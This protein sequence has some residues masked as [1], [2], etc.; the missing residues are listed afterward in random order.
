MAANPI[1]YGKIS[2][3]SSAEALSATLYIANYI[4]ESRRLMSIFKWGPNFLELNKNPL[5]D[6]RLAK[7]P[8]DMIKIEEE[9]FG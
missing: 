7:T 2:I 4:E 3:L 6:Y 1:N 8:E 5:E 9:Y